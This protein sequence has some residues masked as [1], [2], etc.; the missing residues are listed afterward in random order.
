[1]QEVLDY[2]SFAILVCCLQLSAAELL[3]A[4]G[5]RVNVMDVEKVLFLSEHSLR[6]SLY[7]S[8]YND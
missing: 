4:N 5:A 6:D 2:I 7:I 1:M 3:L 8:F